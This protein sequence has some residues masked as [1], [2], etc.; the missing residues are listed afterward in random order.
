MMT[1]QSLALETFLQNMHNDIE[2]KIN[3]MITDEE[4]LAI[5]NGGKRLRHLLASITFKVCTGGAESQDQYQNFLEGAVG[6]ELAH[7]A[8]LV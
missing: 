2:K 5:L 8:S 1:E 3:E 6:V 7:G 4:I